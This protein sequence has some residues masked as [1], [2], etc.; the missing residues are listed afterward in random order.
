[1]K[2]KKVLSLRDKAKLAS[3]RSQACNTC[4]FVPCSLVLPRVCNDAFIDGYLKG[5]RQAK[6]GF[7]K[8]KTDD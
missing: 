6:R 4:P 3:G 8:T 1:M 2:K 7:I 5:Y